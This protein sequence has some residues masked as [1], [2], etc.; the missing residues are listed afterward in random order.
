PTDIRMTIYSNDGVVDVGARNILVNT[1]TLFGQHDP[2]VVG[3]ADGGFLVS[4]TDDPSIGVRAQRFD[5][6]GHQIGSELFVENDPQKSV[7]PKAA[8]LT[9]GRIASS[10]ISTATGTS[11]PRSS[12]SIHGA[13]SMPTASA[14]SCGKGAMARPRSG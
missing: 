1:T 3:L 8:V 9:D 2:N 11:R 6:G 4:W 7:N 5:A 13:T 14:T 10:T 12:R